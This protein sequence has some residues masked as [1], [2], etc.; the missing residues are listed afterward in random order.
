MAGGWTR[1][2][3][4]QE[5]IDASIQDAVKTAR[6]RLAAGESRTHCEECEAPIPEARRRAVPGVR[7]CIDCQARFE[8]EQQRSSAGYNRRGSKDSQLR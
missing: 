1:D 4:V 5:Q 2:G 8:R 3:G 7:F 6:S